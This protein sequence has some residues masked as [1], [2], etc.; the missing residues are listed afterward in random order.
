MKP[1]STF[2]LIFISFIAV[3]QI[4]NENGKLILNTN[5]TITGSITYYDDFSSTVTYIDSKDSVN[6]CT[7]ECINI[8]YYISTDLLLNLKMIYSENYILILLS[9]SFISYLSAI[10]IIFFN[11]NLTFCN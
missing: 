5:D 10:N 9:F 6:S 11:K 2:I 1:L 3:S 4:Q 7:I 8:L